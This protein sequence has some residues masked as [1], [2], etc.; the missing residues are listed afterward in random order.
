MSS[1]NDQ[2]ISGASIVA[3]TGNIEEQVEKASSIMKK[4]VQNSDG[5]SYGDSN[6]I[7][8]V[9]SESQVEYGKQRVVRRI[10]NV[11]TMMRTAKNGKFIMITFRVCLLVIA[12]VYSLDAS[13][14]S[15]Y[16]VPASSSFSRHSMIS[17]VNVA[18]LVIGSV[19]QSFQAK[20][21]LYHLKTALFCSFFSILYLGRNS[22]SSIF[23]NWSLCGRLSVHSYRFEWCFVR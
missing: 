12:W 19:V 7:H 17:N 2:Q 3:N 23:N 10:E 15:N 5:N 20:F 13:T 14:T 8:L 18:S 4:A 16:V 21:F 22:C 1:G 9:N 11:R 6:E